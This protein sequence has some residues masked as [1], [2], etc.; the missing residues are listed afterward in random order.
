[1]NINPE[2]VKSRQMSFNNIV[3]LDDT[4]VKALSELPVSYVL[5]SIDQPT[6]KLFRKYNKIIETSR[7][8]TDAPFYEDLTL[9]LLLWFPYIIQLG[10]M[11]IV[12]VVYKVLLK[13]SPTQ[14]I[15]Q[16]LIFFGTFNVFNYLIKH[17]VL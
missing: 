2:L 5:H 4:V 11:G 15:I 14:K 6:Y 7:N 10:M 1:M 9:Q 8:D 17:Y 13:K 12:Y 16:L 3:S